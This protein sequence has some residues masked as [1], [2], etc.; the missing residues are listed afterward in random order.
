MGQ[1]HGISAVQRINAQ[2]DAIPESDVNATGTTLPVDEAARRKHWL[3]TTV[4]ISSTPTDQT[5]VLPLFRGI[6]S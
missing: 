6:S 5:F 1:I 3:T 2:G 4:Q